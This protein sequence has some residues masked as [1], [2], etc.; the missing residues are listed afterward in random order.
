M[1]PGLVALGF[2]TEN[3]FTPLGGRSL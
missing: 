3:Q 2:H 1:Q